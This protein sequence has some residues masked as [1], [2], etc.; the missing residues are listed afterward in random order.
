M[1]AN[2][3]FSQFVPASPW[4]DPVTDYWRNISRFCFD[5][6]AFKGVEIYNAD[7]SKGHVRIYETEAEW[8]QAKA[9][10]RTH[11]MPSGNEYLID[12]NCSFDEPPTT[13]TTH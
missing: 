2:Y 8:L 13:T 4:A 10:L 12:D 3:P 9:A 5:A 6:G 1:A 11:R 7:F